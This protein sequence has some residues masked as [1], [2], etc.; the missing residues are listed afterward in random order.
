M[1]G[2]MLAAGKSTRTYPHTLTRPKPLLKLLDRTIIEYNLSQLAGSIDELC[3]VVGYKKEMITSLL[4]DEYEGIK[5]KYIEQKEQLGTGHAL[6]QCKDFIAH[7]EKF[8]VMGSDDLFSK[9]D[10]RR[11]VEEDNAVMVS[12]VNN[13][14]DYGTIESSSNTLTKIHEKVANPQTD[15]ANTGFYVLSSVI[16]D[17]LERVNVSERGEIEL[18]DGI[19]SLAQKAGVNVVAIEDLWFPVTYPWNIL[20]ANILMLSR[21]GRFENKGTVEEN[22]TIKGNVHIGEGSVIKSGSYIEGPVYIGNNCRIGPFAHIR[23]DTV[24]GD[25]CEL[26]KMELYDVLVMNNTTGKHMGYAAHSIIGEN[27]N[28]GAN[29]IT[30]DYRHDGGNHITLVK[31]KKVDTNRRKLGAFIGDNVHTGIGTLIY[32]GRKLWPGTSTLPGEIVKVDKIG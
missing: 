27:V 16:F 4:K 15:L 18:T 19:N 6:L 1:K 9:T 12:R 21:L 17:E 2:I 25:N 26:G 11:C 23:K 32:P 28:L 5:I 22:V 24:I 31:D 7:E 13:P 14:Q 10:I 3:V 8:L 29:T 20:E 30:A